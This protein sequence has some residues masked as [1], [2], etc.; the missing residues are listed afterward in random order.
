MPSYYNEEKVTTRTWCGKLSQEEIEEAVDFWFRNSQGI[1]AGIPCKLVWG[2]GQ[3]PT[4]EIEA[5]VE[6]VE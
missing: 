6:E 2:G 5:K 4:I 1:P 3:L